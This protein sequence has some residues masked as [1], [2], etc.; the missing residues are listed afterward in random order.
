M[1]TGL[2][3]GPPPQHEPI[4][5][6]VTVYGHSNLFYWWPVWVT[7]FL[8]AGLTYM[9][10]AVMAVVPPNTEA[11]RDVLV[12][13][14]PRDALV[15]PAGGKLP[16]PPD[17]PDPPTVQM[18]LNENVGTAFVGVL[19]FTAVVSTVTFRGLTSVIILVVLIAG[20]IILALLGMW[21][22]IFRFVGGLSIRI[23]AAAYLAVA[24]PLLLAW[25]FAFFWYDR[26]RYVIFDQG[27]IRVKLDVGD[28]ETVMDANGVVVEKLRDDIFRHWLLGLGSGD[29]MIRAGSGGEGRKFELDNVV[30]IGRR[31][32]L[33]Q[34][35]L[36]ER[37]VTAAVA[38]P[39]V[40]APR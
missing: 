12:D 38:S 10:G 3:D 32:G 26:T 31:M 34:R 25:L 21:D 27:Q 23:N 2:P 9:D 19:L 35:M 7:G 1:S 36:M 39:T 37:Q 28:S 18:S 4:P 24:V 16:G 29:L 6:Y 17:R 40:G 15:L 13:G 11:R 33:V 22:D 30:F 5:D 14:Q 20:V 8:A